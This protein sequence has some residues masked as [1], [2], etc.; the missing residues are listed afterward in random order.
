MIIHFGFLLRT[1]NK[2]ILATLGS[3][4]LVQFN[5]SLF[6]RVTAL[7]VTRIWIE[8]AVWAAMVSTAQFSL[9]GSCLMPSPGTG[10][11]YLI[12]IIL[13]EKFRCT[14]QRVGTVTYAGCML[15]SL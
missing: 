8:L 6:Y 14:R 13:R 2:L 7:N 10:D 3:H 9:S 11:W 1:K 5:S 4:V 12:Q 15:D